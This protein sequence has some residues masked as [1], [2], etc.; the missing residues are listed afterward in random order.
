M[1]CLCVYVPRV[2]FKFIPMLSPFCATVNITG[3]TTIFASGEN[4]SLNKNIVD[5]NGRLHVNYR[6][7]IIIYVQYA[8]YYTICID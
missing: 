1:L 7:I 2:L 3:E 5:S 8:T 6:N 4:N